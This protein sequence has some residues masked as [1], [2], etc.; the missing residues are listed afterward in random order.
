[1]AYPRIF[2]MGKTGSGKSASSL[3]IATGIKEFMLDNGHESADILVIDGEAGRIL[4]YQGKVSFSDRMFDFYHDDLYD[5]DIPET[6]DGIHVNGNLSP[7]NIVNKIRQV[8]NLYPNIK[9]IIID[10]LSPSWDSI[11]EK[12]SDIDLEGDKK[13]NSFSKWRHPETKPS[14]KKM[15]NEIMSFN[16]CIIATI[17][18]KMKYEMRKVGDTNAVIKIGIE[19]ITQSETEYESTINLKAIDDD[20]IVKQFKIIKDNSGMGLSGKVIDNPDEEFGYSIMKYL[21][22]SGGNNLY[23]PVVDESVK[24][25]ELK[26]KITNNLDKINENTAYRQAFEQFVS[27]DLYAVCTDEDALVKAW[28]AVINEKKKAEKSAK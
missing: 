27:I 12:A 18:E 6:V 28:G 24:L 1:M 5:E 19:P 14:W 16:G 7:L 2:I 23:A 17:R 10:S 13:Y 25:K 8:K 15:L 11:L 3:R 4:Q 20:D 21:Y 22:S 26:E 9:I